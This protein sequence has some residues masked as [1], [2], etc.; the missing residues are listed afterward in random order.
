VAFVILVAAL[1]A[2]LLSTRVT[3]WVRNG[4]LLLILIV[5]V[6]E[7]YTS[8]VTPPLNVKA[9]GLGS[10][11]IKWIETRTT[12]NDLIIGD[13]T[14]DIPFLLQRPAAV[15]F[16]P[17]PY[18][19]HLTYKKLSA[20]AAR[21]CA[22]YDGFYIVL[23]KKSGTERGLKRQY[24]TFVRDLLLGNPERYPDVIKIKDLPETFIYQLTTCPGP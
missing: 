9:E 1:V 17:Y 16:S 13:N 19:I 20:Y 22:D 3:N 15:S 18:T 10:E 4:T 12:P 2:S 5:C 21:H 8:M 14:V 24:G 6:Q 11:R 23:R 7:I